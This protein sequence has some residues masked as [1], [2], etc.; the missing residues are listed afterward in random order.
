MYFMADDV[1]ERS[2]RSVGPCKAD[3]SSLN[4]TVQRQF[5]E[6]ARNVPNRQTCEEI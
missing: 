4:S 1:Y 2:E 6:M 5:S 3:K